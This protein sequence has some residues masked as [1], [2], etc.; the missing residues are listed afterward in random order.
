MINKIEELCK[1]LKPILGSR[2][3]RL[4]FTY[5]AENSD[6][7]REIE[8]ILQILDARTL[9]QDGNENVLLTPPPEEAAGGEYPIGMVSYNE[10]IIYPFGLR[11]NELCQHIGIFGRSGAGKTNAGFILVENLLK[12][13]KPVLILDWKRNYRDLLAYIKGHDFLIFTVGRNVSPFQFNPLIPPAGTQ[14]TTWLKKIIEVIAAAFYVGEGAM[15]LLQKAVNAI[16]KEFGVYER[17]VKEYPTMK[18]ILK[19]LKEYKAKGREVNWL[20]STLRTV[21]SLCFGEMGKVINIRHH[22]GIEELL[23]K[24][25]IME[26]DALTNTDKTCFIEALLLWIHHFRLAEGSREQFKHCILVEEAHHLFMKREAVKERTTEIIMREIRELGESIVIITQHPS[27][28]SIPALGNTYCTLTFNLKHNA[29]VT[30]AANYMLLEN[31]RK[32]YLGKLPVG[33]AAVKM[34][35]RWFEPFLIKMPLIRV[36][37]GLVTDKAIKAKMGGY[38][39]Y[40]RALEPKES[41]FEVIPAGH[42]SEEERDLKE[43]E[44]RFII[45]IVNNPFTGIVNRYKGLE[46]STRNGN[47]I[48]ESLIKKELIKKEEIVSKNGRIILLGLTKKG[49]DIAKKSGCKLKKLNGRAGLEHEYWRYK[50]GKYFEKHGYDVDME[51]P[52]NGKVDIVAEKGEQRIA[53]EIETGK[54]ISRSISN[55]EKDMKADFTMVVSVATSRSVEEKIRNQLREK[56]LDKNKKVRVTSVLAFE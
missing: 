17:E 12:K 53:V 15:Y 35:G 36:E 8:N 49:E 3:D 22:I 54:H 51:M 33:Y 13:S 38:F 4:W 7:K 1:R 43:I 41:S 6:G 25:V 46:I 34:Q 29:D 56:K 30:T 27:L 28:V 20:A 45:D 32:K 24:N 16:Y 44:N 11:E 5:L 9:N 23:K 48:K 14:A 37:K 42:N 40:S 50:I 39:T 18:D 55:I 52:V 10:K 21:A 19:W 31:E 47:A 2:I 26:L